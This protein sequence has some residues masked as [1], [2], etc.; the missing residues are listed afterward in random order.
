MA[1]PAGCAVAELGAGRLALLCVGEHLGGTLLTKDLLSRVGS[2]KSNQVV[3]G[4][5]VCTDGVEQPVC[6]GVGVV[7]PGNGVLPGLAALLVSAEADG[8]ASIS[9]TFEAV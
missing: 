1:G 8:A 2:R 9:S 5:L 6:G 3:D 4:G 7:A